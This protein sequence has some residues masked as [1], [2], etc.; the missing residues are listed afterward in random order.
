MDLQ[1]IASTI[2]PAAA[3]AIAATSA[4]PPPA[5]APAGAVAAA[6]KETEPTLAQVT[7]AV[8]AINRSMSTQS[9]GLEFSVDADSHR[10]IVKVVDRQTKELIRQIPTVET[11]QIAHALDQAHGLLIKQQA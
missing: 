3:T 11:L 2:P 10:T 5:A 4:A 9:R 8:N 7:D 1:A 6:A